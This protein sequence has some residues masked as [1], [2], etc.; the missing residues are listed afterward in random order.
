KWQK[1]QSEF[2]FDLATIYYAT[3]VND[4]TFPSAEIK[5]YVNTHLLSAS[6]SGTDMVLQALCLKK[7]AQVQGFDKVKCLVNFAKLT[8]EIA[9]SN[10][11]SMLAQA[12]GI[13]P[14]EQPSKQDLKEVCLQLEM[15]KNWYYVSQLENLYGLHIVGASLQ[16]TPTAFAD[17]LEEFE[18]NFGGKRI[19][20]TFNKGAMQA[21]TLNGCQYHQPFDPY[22]LANDKNTLVIS[23]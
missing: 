9:K 21:M 16:V 10:K 19:Y 17:N 7:A 4:D 22:T 11:L 12:V 18:L 14:L 3:L 8:K 20:T 6:C 2:L 13:T 5:K 23:Y 15:P 1:C